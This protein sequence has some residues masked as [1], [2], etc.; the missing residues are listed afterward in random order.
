[1][2]R[3]VRS[4]KVYRSGRRSTRRKTQE[5]KPLDAH[6]ETLRN[7]YGKELQT[8]ES[9]EKRK[10]RGLNTIAHKGEAMKDPNKNGTTKTM[11]EDF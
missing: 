1:M 8:G 9:P 4:K 10:K 2:T 11:K 5:E 7:I 6:E 3:T